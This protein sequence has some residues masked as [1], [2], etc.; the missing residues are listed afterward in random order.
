MT[1]ACT[2]N[3]VRIGSI[4][5]A[6]HLPL[7]IIA[8]P[9]QVEDMDHSL[10]MAESLV[11]MTDGLGVGF[12]YKSSFD[13]ANRTSIFGKRGAGLDESLRIFEK[14]K[15]ELGC[16]LTTDVHTQEQCSVVASVV[17]IL[18]VPALLCRQTDLLKAAAETKKPI[19][20]KKGQFLAPWDMEH[21]Y[22]K[23]RNFGQNDVILCERGTIFGYNNLVSDM[24]SIEVMKE[25]GAPVIFDA[26]HSVQQPGGLGVASGGQRRFV[27]ALATA[28]VSV[29]VAG[30]FIETHQDPDNAPSDGPCML[31]LERFAL[32]VE[33]L[34]KYD[35]ITK[36]S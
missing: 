14:I 21:V 23:I 18:Q 29:G 26:T 15:S 7:V 8:G 24:R 2:N 36:N 31:E 3:V 34:K 19:N 17:D 22:N 12:V 25:T 20:V 33:K 35:N 13:K 5:I 6:N 30:V 16:L 10:F 11:K 28:A 1:S 4:E 27:E 32:V 9:C